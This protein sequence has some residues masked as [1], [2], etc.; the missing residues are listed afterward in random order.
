MPKH[1]LFLGKLKGKRKTFFEWK[2]IHLSYELSLT[3][4][5]N[6][7]YYK[8]VHHPIPTRKNREHP[9]NKLNKLCF[10]LSVQVYSLLD[11]TEE[12][13]KVFLGGFKKR[14]HIVRLPPR[15]FGCHKG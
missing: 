6:V 14:G 3:C 1:I 15:A 10:Q 8:S 5:V 12:E 13:R 2:S 11:Q 7:N 4:A 9:G